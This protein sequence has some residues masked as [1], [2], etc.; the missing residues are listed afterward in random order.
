VASQAAILPPIIRFF[1]TQRC[2]VQGLALTGLK[3]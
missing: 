1:A 2:F 3:G